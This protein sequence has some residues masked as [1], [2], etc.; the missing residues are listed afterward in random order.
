MK[1]S[2]RI[3]IGKIVGTF[4]LKGF[5]K[6][7]VFTDF[8]ERFNINQVITIGDKEFRILNAFWHKFQLRI[9]IEGIDSI[10]AA[11]EMIGLE[12]TISSEDRPHLEAEEYYIKDLIGFKVFDHNGNELGVIEQIHPNPAHALIQVGEHYI[13]AIKQFVKKINIEKGFIRVKLLEGM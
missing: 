11:E 5:L 6:V 9:F 3:V 1:N 10:D 8:P 7:Q 12:I 4:G 2:E 13:P